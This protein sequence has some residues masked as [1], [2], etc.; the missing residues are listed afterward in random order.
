MGG[1]GEDI[2]QDERK[3]RRKPL[4]AIFCYF[5]QKDVNLKFKFLEDNLAEMLDIIIARLM[6]L[7]AD[8]SSRNA[9]KKALSFV[10]ESDEIVDQI[11]VAVKNNASIVD[12]ARTEAGKRALFLPQ[13][14]RDAENC[15]AKLTETGYVCQRCGSC[16]INE[17][18]DYAKSIGYKHVFIVPGGS[19]VFKILKENN[20]DRIKAVVGVACYPELG[21]AIERLSFYGITLQAIPLLKTGCINTKVDVEKVKR[22]LREGIK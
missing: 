9:V 22:V 13:C 8:L 17:L 12:F 4:I 18:L 11:Y 10:G 7:G 15:R 20:P 5:K 3:C 2:L 14:L 16:V 1:S 19:M 21:E 6:A